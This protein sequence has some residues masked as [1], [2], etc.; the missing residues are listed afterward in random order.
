MA[1]QDETAEIP[2]KKPQGY[3][4]ICFWDSGASVGSSDFLHPNDAQMPVDVKKIKNKIK[5]KGRQ[6]KQAIMDFKLALCSS[7]L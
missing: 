7:L 3:D 5:G 1:I 6:E 4:V 2:D